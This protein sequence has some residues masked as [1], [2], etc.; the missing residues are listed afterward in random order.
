[1]TVLSFPEK[2]EDALVEH[3]RTAF[4]GYAGV[5]VDPLPDGD[6]LDAGGREHQVW[7][8]YSRSL[9]SQAADRK[10]LRMVCTYA[11]VVRSRYRRSGRSAEP[12]SALGLVQ[13]IERAIA[14]Q[15]IWGS[16]AAKITESRLD[17]QQGGLW[18][19]V[20]LVDMELP[21]GVNRPTEPQFIPPSPV[22]LKETA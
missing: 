12:I 22:T 16:T 20:I 4:E 3:L 17:G 7:V 10:A 21:R 11:I 18:Q 19:Y 6:A 9:P 5:F 1:M 13:F 15:V 14:G 2:L 8:Q